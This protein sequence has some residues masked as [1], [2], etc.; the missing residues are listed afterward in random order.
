MSSS[1]FSYSLVTVRTLPRHGSHALSSRS[2]GLLNTEEKEIIRDLE[3]H[4]SVFIVKNLII[5]KLC[6]VKTQVDQHAKLKL[7]HYI[8]IIIQCYMIRLNKNIMSVVCLV[9]FVN[10]SSV[11]RVQTISDI[12]YQMFN[13]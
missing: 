9:A 6:E 11:A 12:L 5:S 4:I 7:K 8:C 13:L 10:L 3:I 2:A 1:R